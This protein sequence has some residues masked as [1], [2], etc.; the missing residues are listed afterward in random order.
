MLPFFVL[1]LTMIVVPLIY[2]GYLSLFKKRLIGGNSFAGAENYLRA[3]TDPS[4]LEGVARMGL[5]LLVQVPIMLVLSLFTA[6]ALDSG[7][8]RLAK[9]VRLSI[10]VPYAVPSVIAALM[11][12]Y[13]YGPDFGPL[14]QI[15]E[16]IGLGPTVLHRDR[17]LLL[18]H[19]HRELGVHRLQHDHHVRRA[20][21]R[22]PP[23]CTRRPGSTAPPRPGSRWPS[24]S[25]PSG[26]AIML[27]VIFSVIGTF[28]LFNEPA[29]M[30][31]IAPT[32]IGTD[33]TPNCTP[34]TS[35]SSTR[36]RTTRRPWPFC[37]AS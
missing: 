36:T 14:A 29:L 31:A 5:F 3:L 30:R 24:R 37:S 22:S 4:F 12:G 26:P 33:W 7:M 16:A 18:D 9:F 1:F 27:T 13:I 28:Q 23:S 11:W 21:A 19:Q 20:P 10:F 2:A 35:P 17:D 6:L 32:V 25:R 8:I 15:S 34:T